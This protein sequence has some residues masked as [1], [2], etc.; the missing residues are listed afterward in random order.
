[1]FIHDDFLLTTG[2]A[3]R[4]YHAFAA[5][6]PIIDFHNHL[7]PQRV[8]ANQPFT[9]LYELWLAGDHYKWRAM[10]A[11][12]IPESCI[13]GE[14]SGFD[15]FCAWAK[16]LPRLLRNPLYHWTHLELVRYFAIDELLDEKSARRIW[17]AV[18]D[19]LRREPLTPWG[20]LQQFGVRV[21]CTT[22]DPADDLESHR[23]LRK[24]QPPFRMYPTFRP[25]MALRVNRPGAFKLW[26]RKLEGAS[27]SSVAT[28]DEFLSALSQRHAAFGELG[29]RLS[30]HGLP[31]CYADECDPDYAAAIFR[32]ALSDQP[33]DAADTNRFCSFM[34]LF[35]A[36]LDAQAGWT[37]QLH[38]GAA[39]NTNSRQ[40]AQLGPD[41]GVDSIGDWPQATLLGRYLDRLEREGSV[42]R[43]I[44]YN[45]NPADNYA[46]ATMLGNF[47]EGPTPSKLQLGSGW[48]F[49]DQA[50]GIRW[51]LNAVSQTGLLAHMVGMVTDSRSFMSFPRHEYFRRVLCDLIGRDVELGVVPNDESLLGPLIGNLCYGNA[52][53]FFGFD[54]VAH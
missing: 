16:T 41:C 23:A 43:M 37:K 49:L 31:H 8:A 27:H 44:V 24:L 47:Q 28:L 18:A 34:M 22:D 17:G 10:R 20:I 21:I 9:D 11:N 26:L 13:T 4:L 7:S 1:M 15:K 46:V 45:S 53:R 50:D 19:R 25:D 33:L 29:C 42:P 48:W 30:D 3:R 2:A 6:Q 52:R 36:R 35:F 12:G 5:N 51:Q 39:R 54:E 38:L 40:F 14:A 32:K